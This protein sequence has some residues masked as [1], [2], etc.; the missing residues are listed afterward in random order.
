MK[1]RELVHRNLVYFWRTNLAVFGGVAVAVGVLTGA[2]FVGDSVRGSLR[3]LFLSRLGNTETVIIA[4][5]FFRDE[6]ASDIGADP[7]RTVPLIAF[8]GMV[9]HE[10]S[11]R[12]RADVQVYGVD[13]RFWS[14]HDIGN[15][16]LSG[17]D[18]LVTSSLRDELGS[19]GGD[20][21]LLRVERPSAVARG[22]LHGL[23]EDNGRTLRLTVRDEAA[24]ELSMY[25]QQ[26]AVR[27]VFVPLARL[28]RDLGQED[29]VNTILVGG[30]LDSAEVRERLRTSAKLSDLG[31]RVRVLEARGALSIESDALMLS[32]PIIAAARAEAAARS[33]ASTSIF[34]YLAN[35]LEVGDSTVPY[36]LVTALDD[37]AYTSL[38]EGERPMSPSL[39]LNSWA[40]SDLGAERGDSLTMEFY[41]W[42]NEGQIETHT[43]DFVVDGVI[44]M[45][46]WGADRDVAPEFPGISET[47]DLADWDPPFP[48][49]LRR[50]RDKDEDYWDEHRTTPKAFIR[51]ARGQRLWPVQQGTLTSFRLESD[52]PTEDVF[53]IESG[54]RAR[55]DPLD[56][57]F[58]VIPARVEGVAASVG[59]TDFG[60]YFV[61]FSY[62]LVVAALLL[63][64]LFFKLGVEQRLREIGTLR[65]VGF[66]VATIRRVF[67]LEG[68]A[69]SVAG[70]I[71]GIG[72]ALGY[73]WIVMYGLRTWWVD[74]V[75]TR[76]LTLHVSTTS[77]VIGLVGGVAAASVSIAL[78]LQYLKKIPPRRLLS[79][80]VGRETSST[81]RKT[82]RR[83]GVT[84]L[85]TLALGIA[86]VAAACTDVGIISQVFGFFGAGNLILVSALLF[87]WVWLRSDSQ[88]AVAGHFGQGLVAI[89]RLGFRNATHRPGRSL[90]AI[91]LIAFA[92]FTIVAVDAFRKNDDAIELVRNSGSGGYPLVAESLLPLHWD[93]NTEE[94]RDAA[95]LPYP[96]DPDAVDMRIE[97]FRLRPGDDASCLNL[98]RPQ[99]PRVLAVSAEFI[100][101]SRFRFNASLASTP[102][103]E[104]NPWL[105]LNE[106]FSDGA[107]PVIGDANSMTYVL[108]L[109]LGDDFLLPRVGETPL[110]LRLVATLAD[111]IFQGELL[112]SEDRFLTQFPR[113]DGFRFLLIDTPEPE[114]A[115]NLLEQRL[116][117]FGLDVQSTSQKLAGFHR[118]ENTYLS[119]FQTLGGLGLVLGTFGLAAVLLRN[120]LERRRELA[121]L[122]AVGY[123]HKDFSLMIAAENSLLLLLGLV[124]GGVA[125]VVA[126][127]PALWARGGSFGGGLLGLLLLAVVVS[128]FLSSVLAVSAVSRAP[129][130]SSLKA[131]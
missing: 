19:G 33:M 82:S 98:Y 14:F 91:A 70:G 27:A 49:D 6:L 53:D 21:L 22:S 126:I 117:D 130:L 109:G 55:L 74:A 2:L 54:L 103:E 112:M 57:G 120:V 105:L 35:T 107:V 119:T 15:R 94:G 128:G 41:V 39:V 61:Y 100:H 26:D 123:R 68:A 12:R 46:G 97:T 65:A 89:S 114:A 45:E 18:A 52:Q 16:E 86:L 42:R 60:E 127:A 28:Q 59:A 56:M 92:S 10:P 31:V 1:L 24:P 13:E 115:S 79:G 122:R 80:D 73:A 64:G 72:I 9:T 5:N 85:V 111:S 95:N 81:V 23:K 75:G 38:L 17:R 101:E 78:T 20:V 63:T 37:K 50:V 93:P 47:E 129:L 131:E 110:R 106:S 30:D 99:N 69:L 88:R 84:A 11:G 48:I 32:E 77:L 44:E 43:A 90:V 108:H 40:A 36:S 66:S 125:A 62:F 25:P 96:G 116:S 104:E 113:V 76:L 102:E 71:A 34:T 67:W 7:V 87:Q 8:V 121:L 124:T 51:L 118:V 29:K 3:E 58:S 83:A 4:N